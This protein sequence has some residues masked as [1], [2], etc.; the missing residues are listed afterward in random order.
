[1]CSYP[2]SAAREELFS[3]LRPDGSKE[4]SLTTICDEGFFRLLSVN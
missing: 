1:M 3:D 2:V 4:K